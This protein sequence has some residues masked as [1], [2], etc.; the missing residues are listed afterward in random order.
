MIQDFF[1]NTLTSTNE[2]EENTLSRVLRS[3]KK[4]NK[5]VSIDLASKKLSDTPDLAIF[6]TLK[7]FLPLI[8]TNVFEKL[9][10][11]TDVVRI[12]RLSVIVSKFFLKIAT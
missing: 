10:S 4:S 7:F 11:I 8:M 5:H 3:L 1:K 9:A 6:Y 12:R 2:M